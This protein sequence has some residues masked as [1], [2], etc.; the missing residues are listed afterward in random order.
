MRPPSQRILPA[1]LTALLLLT[2]C[3]SVSPTPASTASPATRVASPATTPSAA[4][5]PTPSIDVD[6]QALH[7]LTIEA[8]H[9]FSGGAKTVFEQQAE[10]FTTS[11]KWGIRVIPVDYRDQASLFEAVNAT[12]EAGMPPQMVAALPEQV[13]SWDAASRVVE[14]SPYVNDPTWGMSAEEIGGIAPV[15][16]SQDEVNG[17]RLGVPALR[18]A[19]YLVYNQ[20]WAQELGFENPPTTAD[21]FLQQ[22]CA[23]N[24]AFRSDEILQNDGYGGWV[25]DADWQTIYSWLLAFGGGAVEDDSYAFRTDPNL[26][27]L[28]FLKGLYDDHCAWLSTEPSP[29]DSFARRSALFITADMAVI[30]MMNKAMSRAENLDEWTLLPFPGS[31][32]RVLVAYGPSYSLLGTT[33]EGQLAAWIFIRWLLLP[34]NQAGWVKMAAGLPLYFAQ[35]TGDSQAQWEAAVAE[36]EFARGVPQLA[37]WRQ[38]KYVLED[39]VGVIFQVNLPQDQVPTILDEIDSMAKELNG[40]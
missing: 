40:R 26:E 31:E 4:F 17:R 6:E 10:R 36:L 18:S 16:W 5:S 24:A 38:V 13:L 1:C 2:G 37:S 21:E 15:F 22:A 34:E 39:G 7:F 35:A 32:E 25:V 3:G 9:A 33:P 20:T 30:P 29:L 12:L 28:Q 8:W 27:A 11:N 14:L 19:R 23:A